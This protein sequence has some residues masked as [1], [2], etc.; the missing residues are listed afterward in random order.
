MKLLES[1]ASRLALLGIVALQ[2]SCGDSSGPGSS[3][4]SIAANSS[5]TLIAAPGA[6]VAELPSVILRDQ[7]GS[8]VGGVAVTFAVTSGGGT[9]T[10][11]HTTTN[12]SGIATVGSWTLGPNGGGN[13]L[14]AT[15]GGLSVTFT[16]N[17]SD[18]CAAAPTHTL[19]STTNGQLSLTDC[20]LSDGSFVDF[21]AVTIPTAGTYIFSQTSAAFD[22]YIAMLSS[23]GVLV[24]VND[25]ATTTNT[26]SVLKVL[27]PPGNFIIGANSFDANATGA[28]TLTS[29][30]T[31]AE[32]T[33][34]ED[35]FVLRGITSAQSLQATDCNINGFYGDEY[36]ILL[37]AGQSITIS[38]NSS[39][40][41]SYLEVHTGNSVTILAS[42][43][44]VNSSTKNAQLI[45]TPTTSDFYVIA[46]RSTAAGVTGAYTLVIQ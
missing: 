45:F 29:A 13:T 22:T 25:D 27:V 40:L 32:V 38:M 42:N 36:V 16:A 33:N 23:T 2:V 43:D 34:C 9:V 6:E 44:D 28:Y 12:P 4:A 37:A 39:V 41:D 7:S 30:P 24:G 15:A 1:L 3:A 17:A 21:Y 14:V 8:P 19:G 31:T 10:G 11:D 35:A 26:N 46:A 20:K 5:T 18:P